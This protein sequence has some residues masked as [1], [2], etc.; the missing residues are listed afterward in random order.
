[1]VGSAIYT[2]YFH[3]LLLQDKALLSTPD[4]CAVLGEDTF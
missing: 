1:M 4:S 3:E 2:N